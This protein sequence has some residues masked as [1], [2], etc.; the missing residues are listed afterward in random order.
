[1]P[2]STDMIVRVAHADVVMELAFPFSVRH[3]HCKIGEDFRWRTFAGECNSV[4]IG[5]NDGVVID[6]N[7][8]NGVSAPFGGLI[9][10]YGDLTSTIKVGGHY[11]IVISGDVSPDA[12]IDASG[13]C[14]LFVGGEFLGELRSSGSTKVWIE[15]KFNGSIRTGAPHTTIHFG[16]DYEG[17]VSPKE[18]AALLDL[19][20]AGFASNSSLSKI[21]DCGYTQFH[22]S[23]ARSDVAPGL[24]PLSE[25]QRKKER[26]NSY[27]RWCVKERNDK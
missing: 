13:F 9:H 4:L 6:G 3:W 14:H 17:N 19:T 18:D 27:N 8:S 23:I 5:P 20:V 25:Y 10:I 24:Y 11:E 12:L 15:S 7:C 1:M 22:A 2:I 16:S 26:G 21:V